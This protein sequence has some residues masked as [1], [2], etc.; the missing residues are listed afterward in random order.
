MA[1]SSSNR[2]PA[3][4]FVSSVLPTP[5]GPR[6]R[7]LPSGRPGSCKPA[8]ARRTAFDT[9][10]IAWDCPMTR[11]DRMFSMSSSFSR[12]PSIIRSTGM[13]VQRDTTP[14]ISSS[15]T[16][17]LSRALSVCPDASASFFSSSGILP[18]CSSPAFCRSPPRCACSSSIR[19][20]SRSSLI[21]ASAWILSRSF[22]QRVVS[23]LDCCSSS[24]SS[25]RRFSRRSFEASSVS[26]CNACSSIRS[27]MIRRS[28]PSISSGLLSTSMRMRL[29]ASSIRSIALSGRKRFWI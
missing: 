3:N 5:V 4:A 29:A 15:V 17:S 20:W 16:S 22:C 23:S 10:S 28:S 1:L 11:F 13:P 24:D 27:W 18:Y 26:F 9:A 14:A 6:N 25:L 19:A 7:K 8:R 12:S 2:K 21:R